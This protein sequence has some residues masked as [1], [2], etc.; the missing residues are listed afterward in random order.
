M[1]LNSDF[2]LSFGENDFFITPPK[3]VILEEASTRCNLEVDCPRERTAEQNEVDSLN[4]NDGIEEEQIYQVEPINIMIENRFDI[5]PSQRS[6]WF[7]SGII[8]ILYN[9]FV[10][11]TSFFYIDYRS[12][13]R[14]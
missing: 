3:N 8:V 6:S 1:N 13:Y 11:Y 7:I 10:M 14:L 5:F 4:L 12:H 2:D 9:D